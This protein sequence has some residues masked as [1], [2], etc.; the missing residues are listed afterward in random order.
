MT[1]M[2]EQPTGGTVDVRALAGQMLGK[3]EGEA[4]A[5][6]ETGRAQVRRHLID[7]LDEAGLRRGHGMTVE[8]H[9]AKVERIVAALAYMT[10]ANLITLA[11]LTLANAQGGFKD[12][13]PP[14]AAVLNWGRSLQAPPLRENRI[15]TSWLASVEGPPAR[16]SGTHVELF[17]FLRRRLVPPGPYD[18]AQIRAEADRNART[19]AVYRERIGK[20][21]A[22]A[23]ER[24]W[25][26]DYLRDRAAAEAI[27]DLGEAKREGGAE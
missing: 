16:A 15:I 21:V 19:L 26:A 4:A 11:E 23:D 13:W 9:A 3:G 24:A 12:S 18:R 20:G 17:R 22:H 25:V 8:A 6:A 27:I 10:P 5:L 2:R 1:T 14:E 7:R